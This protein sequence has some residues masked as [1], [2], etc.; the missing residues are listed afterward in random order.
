MGDKDNKWYI[1]GQKGCTSA[2]IKELFERGASSESNLRTKDFENSSYIFFL[3]DDIIAAYLIDSELGKKACKEW[4]KVII[5][6]SDSKSK[7]NFKPY[8]KVLVCD[9]VGRWLATEFSCYNV[10]NEDA[11]YTATN[12]YHYRYCLP[13]EGNEH[14]NGVKFKPEHIKNYE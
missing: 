9:G 1:R 10:G 12:G 2:I 13:Y 5:T 8:D 4:R 14:L 6:P 7:Q 3:I 11:F